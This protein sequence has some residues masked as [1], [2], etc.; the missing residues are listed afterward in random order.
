MSTRLQYLHRRPGLDHDL[1]PHEP[2]PTRLPITWPDDKSLA[3]WITVPLEVFPLDAPSQPF[4]P[5]GALPLGYPDLWNYS[6]RDYGNRIGIYRIIRTLD[7]LGLRATAVVNS[8]IATK[9]PRILD[10]LAGRDWEFVAGGVNMGS[11]HHGALPPD[12][13][14]QTIRS[15]REVLQRAVG[16]PVLGWHS[17]D[18]SQSHNTMTLLAEQGFRY[19]TDWANDDMPYKVTTP[20]GALCALPL[21]HE[22]ADRC[23][24]VQ[25]S[26]TVDDYVAQVLQAFE[27]L[28]KEAAERQAGR[29][30]SLSITPWILGYPHRIAALERLLRQILASGAVWPATGMDI[31]RIF[32]AQTH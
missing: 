13:E 1:F 5:L 16:R 31:V 26:L 24:L 25:H 22:W 20:A 6:N 12:E 10:E 30:L 15:A 2:T 3:L 28:N 17:P 19:V 23:L 29:I 27:Q 32:E 9:Y 14:R 11:L 8:D 7:A 4:R 21:T 18:R